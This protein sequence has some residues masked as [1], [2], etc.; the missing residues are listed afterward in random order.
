MLKG[1]FYLDDYKENRKEIT[2]IIGKM[3]KKVS[4]YQGTLEAYIIDLADSIGYVSIDWKALVTRVLK[5]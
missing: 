3:F 4:L 5:Q 2:E 1:N